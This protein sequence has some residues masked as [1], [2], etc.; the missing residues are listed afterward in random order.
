MTFIGEHVK[1]RVYKI[2]GCIL[3]SLLMLVV[4]RAWVIHALRSDLVGETVSSIWIERELPIRELLR[5]VEDD[6]N[7]ELGDDLGAWKLVASNDLQGRS[8]A[9]YLAAETHG[10]WAVENVASA[11]GCKIRYPA[12][13]R[14]RTLVFE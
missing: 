10:Y 5:M 4:Y 11:Y 2:G 9:R 6:L 3:L 1:L 7:R 12:L 8:V 14:T 13:G